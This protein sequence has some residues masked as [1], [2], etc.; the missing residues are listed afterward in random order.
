MPQA[1]AGLCSSIAS[2][3][4][5]Q[6]DDVF[7]PASSA[8]FGLCGFAGQRRHRTESGKKHVDGLAESR[9]PLQIPA[10]RNKLK[11]GDPVSHCL[12]PR[13]QVSQTWILASDEIRAA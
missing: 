13:A 9:G 3:V 1:C 2:G 5:R 8:D 7:R 11:G 6:V 4:L 10:T 12:N